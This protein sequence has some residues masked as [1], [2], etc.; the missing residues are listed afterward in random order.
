MLGLIE[1][2]LVLLAVLGWAVFELRG[3]QKSG[4][5]TAARP[6]APGG[7][8]PGL[9]ADPGHPEGQQGLDPGGPEPVKGETLVDRQ[10]RTATHVRAQQRP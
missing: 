7:L 3:L 9:A 1:L 8:S 10:D 4:D 6:P 2:L 5:K